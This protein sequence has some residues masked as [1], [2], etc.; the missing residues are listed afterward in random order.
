M[1]GSSFEKVL[2][3]AL[4]IVLLLLCSSCAVPDGISTE[5]SASQITEATLPKEPAVDALKIALNLNQYPGGMK[6]M[7]IKWYGDAPFDDYLQMQKNPTTAGDL[8]MA[9]TKNANQISE[10]NISAFTTEILKNYAYRFDGSEVLKETT[11]DLNLALE[12]VFD[13][14]GTKNGLDAAKAALAEVHQEL[15]PALATFLSAAAEAY[16]L[17][18]AFYGNLPFGTNEKFK[19]FYYAAPT[20]DDPTIRYAYELSLETDEQM[21]VHAG[22]LMIC[23]T[24]QLALATEKSDTLT[25]DGSTLTVN[26]PFG[27]I[28]F[29]TAGDDTYTSPKTLLLLDPAGNDTYNGKVAASTFKSLPISVLIDTKGDDTYSA[30]KLT[31]G[32]QGCGILGCGILFDLDGNDTYSAVR[33]AQGFAIHGTGVLY[34]AKGNDTYKSEISSQASAYYGYTLLADGEGNDT[35]YAFGYSQAFAGNRAVSFLADCTGNDTYTIEPGVQ[36]GYEGMAYDF[37]GSAGNWSQGAGCGNR[38]ISTEKRGLA[39]G[40]A[41]MIDLDG[42]DK[43]LGGN[44][45]QATGYWSGIGFLTD[46]NGNDLYTFAYYSQASV[47]HY[48]AGTLINVG[49]NDQ[50]VSIAGNYDYVESTST[51]QVWDRGIALFVDE[52]GNDYYKTIGRAMGCAHSAYDEKGPANQDLTYAFFIETEGDDYYDC[53]DELA[54]GWGWGGYFFDLGG[55]DDYAQYSPNNREECSRWGAENGVFIDVEVDLCY[56]VFFWENAKKNYFEN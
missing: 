54:Y 41:G 5:P 22:V 18:D 44:W 33:M 27:Q 48:G 53:E 25:K 26:T 6:D 51:A 11:K 29:G 16:K 7:E 55:E 31:S 14:A 30:T 35:Y 50:Y 39:G 42:N 24:E 45:V 8:P 4:A 46:M 12:A 40:I 13:A 1:M 2:A 52:G 9:I 34:D 19:D 37:G 56:E 47:A 17:Y 3:L 32:T 43:Y 15:Q 49:G 23:A 10:G 36:K 20:W 28:V 38:A 21:R